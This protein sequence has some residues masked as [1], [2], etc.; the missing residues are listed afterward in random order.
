MTIKMGEKEKAGVRCDEELAQ[1]QMVPSPLIYRILNWNSKNGA[2][3][4]NIYAARYSS[5]SPWPL[6]IASLS[7][8]SPDTG[9]DTQAA[10]PAGDAVRYQPEVQWQVW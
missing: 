1:R 6:A 4:M 8:L 10:Q 9:T 5:F 7:F 2:H 3:V